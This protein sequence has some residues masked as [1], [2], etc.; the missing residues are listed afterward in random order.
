VWAGCPQGWLA[1]AFG[2]A[3]MGLDNYRGAILEVETLS[4]KLGVDLQG[5]TR[6]R[7]ISHRSTQSGCKQSVET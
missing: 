7:K 3:M 6:L 2:L 1:L 5:G 4:M